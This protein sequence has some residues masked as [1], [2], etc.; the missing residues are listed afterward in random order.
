MCTNADPTAP[1]AN[2]EGLGY[3]AR[4]PLS[5]TEL[6]LASLLPVQKTAALIVTR[7]WSDRH[8]PRLCYNFGS[9]RGGRVVEGAGLENQYGSHSIVGSNPTLSAAARSAPGPFVTAAWR[10]AERC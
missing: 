6:D 8:D 5:R 10:T 1:H 4:G 2:S 9:G 7:P 3:A